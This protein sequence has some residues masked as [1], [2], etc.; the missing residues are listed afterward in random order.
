MKSTGA[1]SC[2]LNHSGCTS[3]VCAA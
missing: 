2:R 3:I 1:N